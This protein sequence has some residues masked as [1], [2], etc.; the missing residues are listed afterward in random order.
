VPLA[1]GSRR[2]RAATAGA[3][4]LFAVMTRYALLAPRIDQPAA[5]LAVAFPRCIRS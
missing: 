2:L 4:M 5:L 3:A 1:F